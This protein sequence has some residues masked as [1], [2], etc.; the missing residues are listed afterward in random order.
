VQDLFNW[1]VIRK[2]AESFDRPIFKDEVKKYVETEYKEFS[3]GL[4]DK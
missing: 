1:Q 3:R 2:N 4:Q